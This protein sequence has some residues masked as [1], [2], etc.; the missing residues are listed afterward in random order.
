MAQPT[1]LEY[2]QQ[3]C[4]TLTDRGSLVCFEPRERYYLWH[5]WKEK[6]IRL[7]PVASKG[8]L[9]VSVEVILEGDAAKE[10]FA[11]LQEQCKEINRELGEPVCWRDDPDQ[12][13]CYIKLRWEGCDPS[14]QTQWAKQHNWLHAKLQL[15]HAVFAHRIEGLP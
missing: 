2:W 4:Q 7:S 14:D 6:N 1:Y 10:R 5:R 15:F 13:Q 8:K 9:Y 12:K 11:S 3:F